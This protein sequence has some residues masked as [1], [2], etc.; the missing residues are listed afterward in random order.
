MFV[1]TGRGMERLRM[2]RESF[3]DQFMQ[4]A[5]NDNI[6]YIEKVL[7][8]YPDA[9]HWT[10]YDGKTG[11]DWAGLYGHTQLI[12]LLRMAEDDPA[13]KECTIHDQ[14]FGKCR[15]GPRKF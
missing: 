5:R 8:Q 1:R 11:R 14:Q 10:D 13:S 15:P 2:V 6:K 7:G 12:N 9:C 4:A 3:S